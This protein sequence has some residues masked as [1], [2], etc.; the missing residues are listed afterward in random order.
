MRPIVLALAFALAGCGG[1]NT[2]SSV[3]PPGDAK[4]SESRA[5][6]AGAHLLQ[7]KQPLG[8]LNAYLHGFHFANGNMSDQMEAHHYCGFLTEEVIQCA[9]F[10]GNAGDAKLIGVEYIVSAELYRTLP[11]EEKQLWHSHVHEVRSGQLIAPGIPDPVERELMEKIVGTYGKTWHTW[12]THHG[13]A[14]PLG[15]PALMMGF[16]ADGQANVAMVEDRDRRLDVS[17][18]DK[19]TDRADIQ[20]PEIDPDADAWQRGVV[21]R[22]DRSTGEP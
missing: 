7:R 2:S 5:L 18:T 15:I 14:L 21:V 8:S 6:E 9:L 1:S 4:T 20:Y 11:A 12:Q 19:R 22:L 3:S 13:Q 16:T 10:D 17:S